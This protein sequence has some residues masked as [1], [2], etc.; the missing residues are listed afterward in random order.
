MTGGAGFD[1]LVGGDGHDTIIGGEGFNVAFGDGFN[2]GTNP[3]SFFEQFSQ[4]TKAIIFDE[5][6]LMLK[7]ITSVFGFGSEDS[8]QGCPSNPTMPTR[9]KSLCFMELRIHS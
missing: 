8:P 1:L 2:I 3:F 9:R 7:T 5:P 4:I 6:N